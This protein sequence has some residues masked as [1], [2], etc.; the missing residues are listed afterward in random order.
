MVRWSKRGVHTDNTHR[1]WHLDQTGYR[2]A[3]WQCGQQPKRGP[4]LE[5]G[6][7]GI[8]LSKEAERSRQGNR[9]RA[10][11]NG[12]DAEG[13]AIV[14]AA[15][16]A[17][18]LRRINPDSRVFLIGLH[19]MRGIHGREGGPG[20]KKW[21]CNAGQGRIQKRWDGSTRKTREPTAKSEDWVWGLEGCRRQ[22]NTQQFELQTK[23]RGQF[24]AGHGM[25][26]F[27]LG[28][29]VRKVKLFGVE[30]IFTRVGSVGGPCPGLLSEPCVSV[31][32]NTRAMI[33]IRSKTNELK[34]LSYH[35]VSSHFLEAWK[36]LAPLLNS[37]YPG[38]KERLREH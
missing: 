7:E 32:T 18:I 12:W 38:E 31:R 22:R 6:P 23:R 36:L 4:K 1:L 13:H 25:S 15:H 10:R 30:T 35:L 5:G 19:Q 33:G 20:R 34:V 16:K 3:G 11:C 28:S 2:S 29:P 17:S 27:C 21:P 14:S 26:V 8:R 24:S 37:E 9:D